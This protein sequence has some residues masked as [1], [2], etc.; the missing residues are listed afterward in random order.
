MQIIPV[1]GGKGGVGKSLM[2][3]N[4]AIALAQAGKKTYLIDMDLGAS[5]LH[6]ILGEYG[7]KKGIGTFLAKTTTF[8]DIIIKTQYKNLFFIP[9]DSEI[10]GY[11]ALR[12]KHRNALAK[13]FIKLDADYI[14]I[15]LG[16]GTHVGVLDFFLLS[17]RGIVV[18][19]PSVTATLDAYIFLKN[20]IFRMMNGAFPSGSKGAI[21]LEN[22]RK[23]TSSMQMMYIP[24][25]TEELKNIDPENSKVFIRRLERF[26]PRLILNMIDDPKDTDKALK[27]RRSCK[28][29]LDIDLEHLGVVYRD[30]I[31]DV[32][33]SSKLP[34]LI[35]KP[36]SMASQAIYRISEKIIASGL[37]SDFDSEDFASFADETFET[38][39]SEAQF[40]YKN[41]MDYITELIGG[42]SL[43]SG[44]LAEMVKTQQFEISILKKEN[45]LLKHKIKKAIESGFK[46]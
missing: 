29:S 20:V 33:L 28:Q 5:N 21:F 11:A 27:I 8:E 10:P 7:A 44:D 16:A 36:Q 13:E 37:P 18:T 15:D 40:D 45:M 34:V 17:A 2:A 43:T 46:V 35:Y 38:A 6:L 23:D 25:I 12:A 32:A 41:R 4:L 19:T 30:S 22:L 9:G 14:I 1:A 26:K 3:A 39:E 24:K 42:E 31:Q